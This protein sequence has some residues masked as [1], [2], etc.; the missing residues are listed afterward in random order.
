[1]L[2][3]TYLKVIIPKKSAPINSVPLMI[4][5]KACPSKRLPTKATL[6]IDT[7]APIDI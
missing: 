4:R 3:G 5:D 6:P 2:I 7:E 1:M